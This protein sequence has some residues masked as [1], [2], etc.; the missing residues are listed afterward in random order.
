MKKRFAIY[1]LS[2]IFVVGFLCGCTPKLQKISDNLNTYDLILNFDDQ[3]KTLQGEQTLLYTNKTNVVLSELDF[4]LYPNAF[5]SSA[6]YKPVSLLNYQKAYPNGFSEGKIQINLVK[7]ED[8]EQQFKVGGEDENILIVAIKELYPDESVKVYIEFEVTLPNT[9]H[10]FGYGENTYNFANFYPVVCVYDNGFM[11]K[12]YNSNGDPFYSEMANYNVTLNINKDFVLAN[13][14]EVL[15]QT[16]KEDNITYN[17]Q[18]KAVRDFAFVLS[19]KFEVINT[20]YEDIKI[21]YYYYNETNPNENLE[22][23]RDSVKTFEELFGEYPY[24]VLNVVKTN[25]L[26]GGME[27]P[28]L[29]YIA[30][31]I[32]DKEEYQNVIVHEIAHQWWY[33]LIGSNAYDNA[34]QDE[35]LTEYSTLLFYENNPQ[36][37]VDVQERLKAT[38]ASYLLFIDVY[39]SVKENVDTSMDRPLDKYNSEMEY[40]YMTYVKGAL[41]FDAIRDVMGKNNFIKA[42]KFYYSQNIYKIAKP[43]DLIYAFNKK[44]NKDMESFINSWIKGNVVLKN[45]G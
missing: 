37:N 13:T 31:N 24:K 8:V 23:A 10:R 17:I 26:H 34:W 18:A 2:L 32:E 41:M 44:S 9:I 14:G 7:V 33:N 19:S 5:R 6:K 35:G 16:L 36:Y 11:T 4:H 30:D 38:M 21:N 28:N 22:I 43:E 20:T 12:P 42:L 39:E 3:T 25:F 27:Y 40:V 45:I 15:K 29:V 1:I